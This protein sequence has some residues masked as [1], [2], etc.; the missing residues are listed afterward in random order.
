MPANADEVSRAVVDAAAAGRT[1]RA[2]GNGH[3]FNEIVATDGTTISLEL[4]SG[5][6]DADRESGLVKVGAGTS[7]HELSRL[8]NDHGLALPNL[9]D[10]DVQA[11]AGA[12][13]TG[14]HGTGE[15]YAS[16]SAQVEAVELVAGDGS[17]VTIDDSDPT[18]LRAARVSLGALG[19]V[20]SLTLRCVPAFTLDRRDVPR[21][22]GETLEKLDELSSSHDHFEFYVFP[23][24]DRV[25]QKR[26]DR[27]VEAP[28]PMAAPKRF[29][30]DIVFENWTLAA[31]ANAGKLMPR[32]I[33][34][35]A[36]G[37][38]RTFSNVHKLDRSF[39]IFSTVRNVRFNE[40][41]YAV[42]RESLSEA[43]TRV[44]DTV[45]ER[46]LP[47]NFPIEV[48][49]GRADH[50]CLL[51]TAAERDTGYISV[52]TYRGMDFLPYFHAV[53]EIMDSLNGRPH[54]GKIHWQTA[55]TLAPRYA[56]WDE[57][58]AVRRRLDPNGVFTNPYIE[59][60]LGPP[61]SG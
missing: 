10:I 20:T 42:P 15:R 38:T 58:Q 54:W 30:N 28:R 23:Y 12:A 4:I 21:P 34:R 29:F 41:E 2:R 55:K 60:V 32:A 31:Y 49:V 19:V 39:E 36:R 56:G 25:I 57:F 47:V 61:A 51:A 27:T 18:A 45:K 40:L 9:G 7:I 37:V 13:A 16:V 48:R 33:P 35:L 14:T 1:V 3:S 43:V 59:R 24:T 5:L 8:L 6:I 26:I 11:I 22:L 44:L 17:L 53:E 46:N 50:D 52:H